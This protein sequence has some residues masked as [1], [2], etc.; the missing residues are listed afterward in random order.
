MYEDTP[1]RE[2]MDWRILLGLSVTVIWMAAGVTYLSVIVGWEHFMG[3][4]TA[5]LGSFFEGAFAP[6]AFLWLVIGHFVQQKEISANTR[7]ISMQERSTRR[8]ELH[9]QR[10]S[11]FK[12]LSLV[13]DQ[14][15]SIASFHYLSVFGPSGNGALSQDEF[16]RLRSDASTGDHALFVRQMITEVFSEADK[17]EEVNNILFGT[18]IRR[19]HSENFMRTFKRLLGAAEA[20]DTD[21]MLKDALLQGSASGIYYR[22]LRFYSGEDSSVHPFATTPQSADAE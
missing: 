10:D 2:P 19:R 17:P 8:L 7:A 22:I 11:Y 16:T 14:L 21:D 12:L 18:S 4:P 13:Q 20:V 3:L 15:G 5:D 6:L 9:S 1:S